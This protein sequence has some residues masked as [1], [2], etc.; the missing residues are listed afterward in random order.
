[1]L[2]CWLAA[3]QDAHV[4]STVRL[5]AAQSG[6]TQRVANP[7]APAGVGAL[8]AQRQTIAVREALRALRRRRR[9]RAVRLHARETR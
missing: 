4:V 8:E 5:S 1:M 7:I 2:K 9:W 3:A 6:D